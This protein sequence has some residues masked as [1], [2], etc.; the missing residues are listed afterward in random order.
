[1]SMSIQA[2]HVP[3]LPQQVSADERQQR[4]FAL[5]TAR[6]NYNYMRSYLDA[7]PMSADLPGPEKF[8]LDY[9]AQVLKVFVPM[10]R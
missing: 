2:P 10:L 6:T 3:T 9:E 4:E 1:M 5:A 7:V 8:S